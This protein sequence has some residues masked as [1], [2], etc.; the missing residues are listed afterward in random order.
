[1]TA[2]ASE[3]ADRMPN[4]FD[5]DPDTRWI[6][7]IGGQDGSSWVRVQLA[8][9]ADVARVTLQIAERSMADYPRVL[10]IESEDAAGRSRALYDGSPYPELAA[11]IVRD[12]RYPN[13]VV[14]LP[15]N[16][17][18]VL[19]VRQ[20]AASRASWSIHELRLWRYDSTG[21]IR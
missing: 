12:G 21:G 17:T 2:S 20:T 13:I 9:A 11:A 5:H 10:R 3:A 16:D 8:H 15:H 18:A 1:L 19:W 14:A 6:A 4:L 7:G